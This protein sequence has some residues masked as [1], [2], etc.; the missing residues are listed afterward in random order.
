MEN[1][2]NVKLVEE[3]RVTPST[4]SL[5]VEPHECMKEVA[6]RK[7]TTHQQI[8]KNTLWLVRRWMAAVEQDCNQSRFD[9]H[10]L[11]ILAVAKEC[12][13]DLNNLLALLRR[14]DVWEI[15][16]DEFEVVRNILQEVFWQEF[17]DFWLLI[18]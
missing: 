12:H 9:T 1:V 15:A 14:Q 18:R 2:P 8:A 13:A 3:L 4:L 11:D 5:N 7:V 6:V 16:S 17:E 10:I